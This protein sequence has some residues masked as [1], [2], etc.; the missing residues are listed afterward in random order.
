MTDKTLLKI[1]LILLFSL[2]PL[3][4]SADTFQGP[5]TQLGI[6]VSKTKTQVDFPN[7][8]RTDIDDT[9]V[10]GKVTAGYAHNFGRFALAGQLYYT[11]GKQESGST[12]QRYH[13][14][15]EVSTLSFELNNSWGIELQPGI[16]FNDTTLIYLSIGYARTTGEWVL[17][18]PYYQDHYSDHVDFDGYSLGAGIKQQL[19]YISPHLYAF[20]EVQKTWYEEEAAPATIAQSS[21]VDYYK[22]ELLQATIGIGWHF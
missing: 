18:R 4:A 9:S 2:A 22:P 11:L 10:N 19:T 17:T 16:V 20:A 5:F 14:S 3:I 7:W 6:S 21:F 12:T 13:E 1:F 8:F 15:E